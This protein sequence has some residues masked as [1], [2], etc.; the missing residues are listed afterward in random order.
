MADRHI[1]KLST[2]HKVLL[3][4]LPQE[5]REMNVKV[6]IEGFPLTSKEFLTKYK[7]DPA[8]VPV[9]TKATK[10]LASV[11]KENAFKVPAFAASQRPKAAITYPTTN[12]AAT[13]LPE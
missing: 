12:K 7:G 9:V 8:L 5:V 2:E 3:S 11:G 1:A 4:Q 10:P 13:K 6:R